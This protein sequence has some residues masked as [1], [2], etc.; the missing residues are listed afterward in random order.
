M[1]RIDKKATRADKHSLVFSQLLL[2]GRHGVRTNKYSLALLHLDRGLQGNGVSFISEVRA[3]GRSLM[4][5]YGTYWSKGAKMW[6]VWGGRWT[7]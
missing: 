2:H 4:A 3:T 1:G 7:S 6:E 5:F